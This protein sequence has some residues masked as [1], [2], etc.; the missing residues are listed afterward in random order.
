MVKHNKYKTFYKKV[1]VEIPVQ[2]SEIEIFIREKT[3][4]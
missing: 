2:A 4:I 1:E 3:D